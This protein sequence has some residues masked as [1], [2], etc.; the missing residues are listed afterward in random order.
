[1]IAQPKKKLWAMARILSNRYVSVIKQTMSHYSLNSYQYFADNLK[2]VSAGKREYNKVSSIFC[3]TRFKNCGQSIL[4]M[5]GRISPL[6]SSL[7]PFFPYFLS[8][9]LEYQYSR[10][11]EIVFL[12]VRKGISIIIKNL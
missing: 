11:V 6:S 8:L 2:T 9:F 5:K 7:L 4:K 1:V 10:S 3:Y 12:M